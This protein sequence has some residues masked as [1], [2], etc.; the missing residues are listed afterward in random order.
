[1]IMSGC[2][3]EL[4]DMRDDLIIKPI[5]I[6]VEI[7]SFDMQA[8]F[9]RVV[10]V[11]KQAIKFGRLIVPDGSKEMQTNE[12]I[13]ISVGGEV[14]DIKVGDTIYYGRYS[15]VLF[16]RKGRSYRVMNEEDILMKAKEGN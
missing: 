14:T 1:M 6:E 3:N 8:L 9:S 13:V 16:E 12:G 2:T 7:K 5:N 15:G 10:V 11:E 4:M